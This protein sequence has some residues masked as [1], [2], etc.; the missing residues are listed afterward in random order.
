[1]LQGGYPFPMG[2]ARA[3]RFIKPPH[4]LQTLLKYSLKVLGSLQ[5]GVTMGKHLVIEDRCK[6]DFMLRQ[7]SSLMEIARFLGKYH[8]TISRELRGRSVSSDKSAPFRVPNRCVH[9][10]ECHMSN[11]CKHQGADCQHPKRCSLCSK[12]NMNC[13]KFSE[14]RCGKLQTSPYVCNGCLEEKKCTLRKKY[15]LP[16]EAQR[17]YEAQLSTAREGVNVTEA[18]L[19]GLDNFVSPLIQKGQSL[20]HIFANNPNEFQICQKTLYSYINSGLLPARNI[21]MPKVCRFRPR[22][23]KSMER[24][25]DSKCRVRRTYDDYLNFKLE[26]PDLHVVQMDTLEGKRGGSVL[27][28]IHFVASSFMLAFY[29]QR[30]TAQSVID[31]FEKLYAVLGK[32]LFMKAF[33]LLLGDNGTEFSNPHEI[34]YATDSTRRTRVFYCDPRMPNQKGSLEENHGLIRRVL[35]KGKSFDQLNQSDINL[36]MNHVNSYSRKKLANKT[37]Y[38]TFKFFYGQE[39]LDKLGAELIPPNEVILRPDLVKK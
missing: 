24:K 22:R 9:R 6:I 4:Y 17:K 19:E 7:G 15:Y 38:E 8:T 10:R 5:V 37:P 35:P 39:L 14:E 3:F 30:N 29:R 32:E 11:L 20:N 34:E 33:P 26:N 31:V 25:V 21:D 2:K 16:Q 28:T 27:L 12:C 23:E 18:E 1:M 13:P 36:V